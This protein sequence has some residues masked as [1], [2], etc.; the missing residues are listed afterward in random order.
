MI[1]KEYV[2]YMARYNAWQNNQLRD[3]VQQMSEA[4]L[5]ADRVAFF[6]SIFATLNH[7]L[8][9]DTLW[10]SR[11]CADVPAPS[12]GST[13][14]TTF[15]PTIGAW[16]GERFRLDGRIRIWAQTLSNLDLQGELEWTSGILGGP[17]VQPLGLCVTHMF[18]HQ[19]HHR[20]QISQMLNE[21]GI[22]PPVS[23]LVFMPED[24]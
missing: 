7:I 18:N 8:W 5:K 23:D 22:A 12:K 10:M 17:V 11:W 16:E 15:T 20:G 21:A 9:G 13:E 14:H 3:I 6:G 1:Q 4:D 19:T 2:L 24:D